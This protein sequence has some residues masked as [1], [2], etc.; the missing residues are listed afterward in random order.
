MKEPVTILGA[1]CTGPLLAVLLA[2]RG[3]RVRI[4]ERRP[5]ARRVQLAAGRSI[6]L[7]LAARG[8]AGLERAGLLDAV[9]PL[10]VPMRGRRLHDLDGS[11]RFLPYGQRPHEQLYSVGRAPLNH[12]LTD[13][14]EAHGV[15]LLFEHACRDADFARGL[16]RVEDLRQGAVRELRLADA[17]VFGADGAG[18]ALRGAMVRAGLGSAREE[19]LAHD[20]KELNIPAGADGRWRM[21]PHALHIWPRGGYMLIALPNTDGSFT[22][23]L[24]LA[25]EGPAPSF[26]SLEAGGPA[27]VRELFA[28]EF[29]DAL[30]LMPNLEIEWAA[31]PAGHMATLYA[32]PWQV[33][34][35]ALLV[36]DAAHAIVPFHGQGMNCAF[37]DCRVI[38]DLLEA[39]CDWG[40][41]FA[42]FDA[43]RRDDCAAIARMAIE[44]YVEMRDTVRDPRF[45]LAK[46]LSLELE[47][48]HPERFIPRYSMVMFHAEI[49]YAEAERRGVAQAAILER[50]TRDARTPDAVD[51]AQAARL[52]DESLPRLRAHATGT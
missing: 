18:S 28:R 2:K 11:T 20:Y 35:R 7:A 48:R 41:C 34:G 9:R 52:V 25:A 31:N 4:Y 36:G 8:L 22:A 17:P 5:D 14:A 45:A 49:P 23:T 40:R 29:P 30:A 21:D 46:E 3:H 33:D 38:D 42:R 26:A 10:L 44:N 6:N 39:G 43:L 27:A 47:R 1:G 37:E 16:I 15:E 13:A 32:A 50:L 51:W 24:F 12:V 19:R